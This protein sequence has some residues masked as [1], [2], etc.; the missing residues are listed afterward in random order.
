MSSLV[1]I[2]VDL[3]HKIEEVL[4][5]SLNPYGKIFLH[6]IVIVA[7][8]II[9]VEFPLL[10]NYFWSRNHRVWKHNRCWTQDKRMIA[11]KFLLLGKCFWPD[12]HGCWN[13]TGVGHTTKC[14]LQQL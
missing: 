9:P 8:R 5:E 10:P 14:M 1:S 12:N 2:Q 11:I 13:L 6:R 3:S 7:E 4:N